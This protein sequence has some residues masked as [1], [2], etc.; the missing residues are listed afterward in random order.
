[1]NK[2]FFISG[3]GANELAFSKIGELGLQKVMVKWIK[4]HK[5]ESLNSYCLRLIEAYKISKDDCI[6]GLSFG[7]IVAQEIAHILGNRSV[8]LIS[9]FR[10]KSDLR[11]PFKLALNI[12]LHK[13]FP[14]VKIPILEEIIANI[15][16]SGSKESKKVLK[17]MIRSTDYGLMRWSIQKIAEKRYEEKTDVTLFNLIGTKDRIVGLWSNETSYSIDGGSHFMVY[18]KSWEIT[19]ILK[20][21]IKK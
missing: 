11:F 14:L 13:I 8:I 2:I 5:K 17:E 12:G 19:K 18:D 9:S 1:M 3:L 20:G 6:S 4:N 16:N 7:G 15:L 21:V 10:D